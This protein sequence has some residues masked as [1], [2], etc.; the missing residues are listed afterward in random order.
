MA[1]VFGWLLFASPSM[2]QETGGVAPQREVFEASDEW[3]AIQYEPATIA[4]G[5]VLDFSTDLDAPAGKHGEAVIKGGHFVFKDGPGKALKLYGVV[6]SHTLPFQDKAGCERTADYLA[7]SGYNWVRL[8]NYNFGKEV[9]KETGSTEFRPGALDQ[10]EYFLAC[11]K[12]RGIYFTLPLNA[13]GFFKAGDVKDIPEFRERDFRFESNGLLPISKDLQRW[14][15]EYS[16]NLLGH[17]NPYT[18][19]AMKDDPALLSLELTNENSLFAV[20]EQHPEFL[21]IYRGKCRERLLAKL[22]REPTGDEVEKEMPAFVVDLQK[23]FFLTMKSFLREFGVRQP[24]TDLNFRDNMVYA[25]PR[26]L[27]DY[28]DVHHYWSLYHSLPVKPVQ[29]WVPY[30]QNFANPNS[31]GW[32][33]YIGPCAARIFGKPYACSEYN[34]CYPSPFWVHTG[35]FE[36]ALAG[37]QDWTMVARCGLVAH[38]QD[39]YH[40]MVPNRIGT[41]ASPV[42]MLSERIGTMLL[43]QGE[44]RPLADK[45]PLVVTP[46]YLLKHADLKGGLRYPRA[47]SNLAL[48]YQLGTIVLDGTEDLKGCAGVVVP[49]D[50]ERPAALKN[51]ICFLAD[52]T[53]AEQ[54]KKFFPPAA[55]DPAPMFQLDAARGC[56]QIV[57]PRTETF[58]LP[59]N[60]GEAAGSCVR[61]TGNKSVGVCFAASRDGKPLCESK[62]VLVLHLTDLKASGVVLE[63]EAKKKDSFIV[64]ERGK[65]PLLVQQNTLGISFKRAGAKVPR[66]WALRYDGTR[67]VEVPVK[68]NAE[69]IEFEAQAVTRPDV[70]G[71]FEVVWQE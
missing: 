5:S 3:R 11:L 12:Q 17:V 20:L 18:K 35:P 58:L 37:M 66:V 44:V 63:P 65:V 36:S 40:V 61:V 46:E 69:G 68:T 43:A 54:L 60:V 16:R 45:L 2:A 8:H 19:L 55:D 28:V 1:T 9:M 6:I 51:H 7:A 56:G 13:W 47:Y 24:L 38:P 10:L 49:P 64:R 48:Q 23:E 26:Q 42:M 41:G 32:S 34:G 50:M 22:G 67:E 29:G 30:Q 15:R 4:K 59:A 52:G 33:G 53:L 27:L 70:F 62:R 14:F 21:G 39:L 57:T 71:A 25:I 31:I